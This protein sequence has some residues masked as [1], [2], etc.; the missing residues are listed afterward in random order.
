MKDVHIVIGVATIALT[1]AAALLGAASF[2]RGWQTR[3]FWWL[4]RAGQAVIVI[5]AALGG[6]LELTDHKAPTLHLIYGLLPIAVSFFAEQFRIASTQMVLDSRGFE[7]SADVA[8][9]P[10][11]EQQAIVR[12][13]LMRELGVMTLAAIVNVV[14][15]A[16]AAGT[17]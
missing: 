12:S 7:S 16:R 4:L 9:L 2:W 15:L 11:E 10:A 13:I 5:Q 6:V 3:W 14:L 8:G 1:G 17:A